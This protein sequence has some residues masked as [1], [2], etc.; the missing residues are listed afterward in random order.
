M[1]LS[2]AKLYIRYKVFSL[3]FRLGK[4]WVTQHRKKRFKTPKRSREDVL[5]HVA[6]AGLS[7]C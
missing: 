1:R 7:F 5:S 4:S 6:P 3:H 2:Q